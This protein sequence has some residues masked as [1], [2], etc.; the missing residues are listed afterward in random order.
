VEFPIKLHAI[1][2]DDGP[3]Q[4]FGDGER[5]GGFAGGRRANHE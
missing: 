1:G 5:K 4:A 3:T 2:V